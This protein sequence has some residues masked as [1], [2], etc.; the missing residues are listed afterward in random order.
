MIDIVVTTSIIYVIAMVIAAGVRGG[1]RSEMEGIGDL[2]LIIFWP[3]WIAYFF[4][5]IFFHLLYEIG[6]SLKNRD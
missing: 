3:L 6:R 1:V 2:F 5:S 4:I